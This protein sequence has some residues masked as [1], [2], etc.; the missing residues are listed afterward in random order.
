MNYEADYC[1]HG[2]G[3]SETDQSRSVQDL[4]MLRT[5]NKE[6]ATRNGQD[7]GL[8]ATINTHSVLLMIYHLSLDGRSS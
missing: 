3:T 5:E 1:R 2:V 7:F 6:L 4:L 8:K